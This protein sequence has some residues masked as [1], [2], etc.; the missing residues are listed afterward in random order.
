MTEAELLEWR[1][2]RLQALI[3]HADAGNKTAFGRRM[4]YRDGALIRQML[5]GTRPITEKFIHKAE[6]ATGLSGWF[7]KNDL[8]PLVSL[9]A[10]ELNGREVPEDVLQTILTMLKGYPTKSRA[11]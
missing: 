6:Q 4:G 10:N 2:Q 8:D 11:A 9:L 5:S 3:D 7:T 1:T